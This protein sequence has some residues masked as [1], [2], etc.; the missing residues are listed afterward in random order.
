MNAVTPAV[1]RLELGVGLIAGAYLL[2]TLPFLRG[3]AHYVWWL[4]ATL[5]VAVLFGSIALIVLRAG[6]RARGA[7]VLPGAGGRDRAVGHGDVAWFFQVGPGGSAPVPSVSDIGFLGF[8]PPA[9]LAI[10]LLLRAP[11]R[12]GPRGRCGSTGSSPG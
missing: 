5:P 6:A 10:G 7:R 9:Y 3:H 11:R 4:D 1:R 2:S 8:Y 12:A